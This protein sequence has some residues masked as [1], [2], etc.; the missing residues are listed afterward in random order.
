MLQDKICITLNSKIYVVKH[1]K[2]LSIIFALTKLK[3]ERQME[4]FESKNTYISLKLI[5]YSILKSV[6]T[7]VT[8][9][10]TTTS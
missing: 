8:N 2:K 10:A 3:K 5:G 4:F 9:G 6:D 1:M 7:V